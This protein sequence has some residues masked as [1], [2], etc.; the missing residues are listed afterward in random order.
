MSTNPPQQPP[1][2]TPQPPYG[3]QP[4]GQPPYGQQ[5]YGQPG[6]Y[7]QPAKTNGLAIAGFVLSFFISLV[8]LILSIIAL[9]Q[10]NGSNGRQKG[11][12]FAIAGIIIGAVSMVFTALALANQ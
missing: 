11:K 1:G 10:I 4:Y 2:Y 8:G 5:P 7:P 9:V 6:G 12:G 3:Q